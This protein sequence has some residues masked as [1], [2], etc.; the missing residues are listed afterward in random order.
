MA[1]DTLMAFVTLWRDTA[2]REIR[3]GH[4]NFAGGLLACAHQLQ[5]LIA[6]HQRAPAAWPG[7]MAGFT[8]AETDR[9]STNSGDTGGP[10]LDIPKGSV[11]HGTD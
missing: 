6:A 7:L 8:P 10:S 3:Q 5:D 11:S 2:H 4:I 9:T 1:D